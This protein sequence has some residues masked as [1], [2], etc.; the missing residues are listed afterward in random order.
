MARALVTGATGFVGRHL[1]AALLARGDQVRCLVRAGSS[2]GALEAPGTC[3]VVRGD[4]LD[5]GSV[6]AAV[7]G[8]DVVYHAAAFLRAP[9]MSAFRRINVDGVGVVARACA[10]AAR[11]P[12]LV[13]VSS[14]AAAGPSVGG[15][16]RA[17]STPPGPVSIYGQCKLDG[18]AQAALLAGSVPVSIVRPPGVFGA[19]DPFLPKMFAM[20]ERGWQ[21]IPTPASARMSMIHV[22]E[23]ARFLI[24]V[25]EEGER[26]SGEVVA[27]AG[28]EVGQGVYHFAHP[29]VTS[30]REMGEVVAAEL[31]VE[32]VRRVK[33]PPWALRGLGALGELGGR[34]RGR[35]SALTRDKVREALAEG[36]ICDVSKSMNDLGFS[37]E[38]GLDERL[39]RA[40][41]A[42]RSGRA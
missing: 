21:V 36:W 10:Q 19:G 29:E 9:W 20:V 40:A 14:M 38:M 15:R 23:L 37:F 17:E 33:V 1:V 8:V 11:G 7:A 12:A 30:M 3:E 2:V 25:G 35:P 32:R 24:Q 34:V 5:E 18:E 27:G 4:V 42:W 22:E 6:V 28:G 26:V 16:P 39:R 41:A 13:V 31:G